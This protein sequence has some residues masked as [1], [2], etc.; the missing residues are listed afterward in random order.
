VPEGSA[1]VVRCV[2]E[3][4]ALKYRQVIEQLASAAGTAPPEIHVVGGGALN[5]SLCQ[6]TADATGLR[7][8]AGP[9]EA[10]A[11]GNLVV[12]AIALGELASLDEARELVRRSF[13]T[14]VYE[15]TDG[16]A[17]EAAYERFLGLADGA[18][19]PSGSAT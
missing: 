3:S 4:L 15:P 16:D 18:S 1:A 7:V 19:T 6:W 2:L 9:A 14:E 12:Q 8:L 5:A 13:A 17:W 10:T 11:V